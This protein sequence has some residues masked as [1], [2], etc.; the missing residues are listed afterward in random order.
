MKFQKPIKRR[1]I[2]R[3][4]GKILPFIFLAVIV[5][6]V[7]FFYYVNQKLTPIYIGYA[8]VQ[9]EKIANHVISEAITERIANV[10]DV[11]DVIQHVPTGESSDQVI[12]KYNTEVINRILADVRT[13]V[14]E[15]LDEIE[16][17]NI[18]IL[19]LDEDIEYD[20]EQMQSQGGVVFFVSLGQ[21]TDLPL[22]GNLGPRIPIRFHVI[23][24]AHATVVPYIKEFGINNAYVEVNI[25]LTVQVKIIVPLATKTSI[26]E[27]T[28]PIAIG[29]VQ[30]PVPQVYS[31]GD[32]VMKPNV[33]V[34]VPLKPE[35]QE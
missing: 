34:E 15:N 4:K 22:L 11:N 27:Q 18:D 10:L 1:G 12:A 28:V 16:K 35:L 17:G 33:D 32:G 3:R 8:E 2:F 14:D 5:A 9:T 13:T 21:V 29:L 24:D 19:P 7:Y 23:G 6:V 25:V 26:V 31:T 20:A 30:G